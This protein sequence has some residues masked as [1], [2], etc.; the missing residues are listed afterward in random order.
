MLLRRIAN[1]IRRQDWFTVAIEFIL[2]VAGVLVA[3]QVNTWNEDRQQ[4]AIHAAYIER[5]HKDFTVIDQRIAEHFVTYQKTT[6]GADYILSLLRASDA[7]FATLEID[8]AKIKTALS[9]IDSWR[10]PPPVPATY[11]EMLAEGQLSKLQSQR[12]R[13]KLA[14]YAQF[15]TILQEFSRAVS[16]SIAH[17]SPVILRHFDA[18]TVSDD[19]NLSGIKAEIISYDLEGMRADPEFFVSTRLSKER[20]MNA[21]EVRKLQKALIDEIF[22]LVEEERSR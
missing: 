11:S 3:L 6:D 17:Q 4:A 12:L 22:A 15:V 10:I 19:S 5:L 13:D 9:W 1:A 14:E 18:H 2:V 8:D 16:Y 21:L 7:E 20:T